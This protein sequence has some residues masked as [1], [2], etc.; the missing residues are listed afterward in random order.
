MI[1]RS[2]YKHPLIWSE[3]DQKIYG[4]NV[5]QK[6]A[7]EIIFSLIPYVEN[8]LKTGGETW[9]ICKHLINLVEGIPNAKVWRNEISTKSIRQELSIDFLSKHASEL[10]KMG[11]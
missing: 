7:S 8:H 4:I 6:S 10:Q 1:G 11:F 9:D 3:I 5:D 2:A